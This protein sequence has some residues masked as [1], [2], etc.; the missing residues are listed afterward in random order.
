MGSPQGCVLSPLLYT[1]Y[2]HD[3]TPT[4]PNNAIIKF[5]D[6]T[7]VAGLISGG[8]GKADSMNN[9]ILNTSKSW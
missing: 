5:A 8:G 3:C 9:L 1:L 6:E 4:Y 2:T 7:T